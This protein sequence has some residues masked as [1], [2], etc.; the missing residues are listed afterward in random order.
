MNDQSAKRE[1]GVKQAAAPADPVERLVMTGLS[2]VIE[3]FVGQKVAYRAAGEER[4]GTCVEIRRGKGVMVNL[5]TNKMSANVFQAKIK[6]D[7]GSR[8]FWTCS[9]QA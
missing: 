7:D 6:P 2:D 3:K 5:K 1:E 9:F 8:A 4:I